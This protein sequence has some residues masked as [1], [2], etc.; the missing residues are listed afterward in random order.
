MRP[1]SPRL[2]PSLCN[3]KVAAISVL[4]QSRSQA[5]LAAECICTSTFFCCQAH[6]ATELQHGEALSLG[7]QQVR[8]GCR[9]PIQARLH[10]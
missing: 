8:N 1:E 9:D 5:A 3:Y 4:P 10:V 6:E 2:V 7:E